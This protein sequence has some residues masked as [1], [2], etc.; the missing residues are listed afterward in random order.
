VAVSCSLAPQLRVGGRGEAETSRGRFPRK[1]R[2]RH[3]LAGLPVTEWNSEDA[4]MCRKSEE[5]KQERYCLPPLQIFSSDFRK[6]RA[7]GH[8][9]SA[10]KNGNALGT[11]HREVGIPST[12]GCRC[13]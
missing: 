8:S 2:Q 9:L 7:R 4:G 10:G 3:S 13:A 5:V 6:L 11:S 1:A 12:T